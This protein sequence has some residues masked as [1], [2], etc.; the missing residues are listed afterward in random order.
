M[1]VDTWAGSERVVP[2]WFESPLWGNSP[3]FP[4]ARHLALPACA[5]V[6]GTSQPPPTCVCASLSRDGV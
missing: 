2:S 3:G 1:D 4:W 6:S 5:S